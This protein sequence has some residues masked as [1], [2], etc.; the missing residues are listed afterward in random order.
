MIPVTAFFEE[1]MDQP[2]KKGKIIL[3]A[4]ETFAKAKKLMCCFL[5]VGSNLVLIQHSIKKYGNAHR[6]QGPETHYILCWH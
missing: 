2:F 5:G 4:K 6:Y 3:Q 1:N